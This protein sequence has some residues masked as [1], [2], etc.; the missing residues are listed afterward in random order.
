MGRMYQNLAHCNLVNDNYQQSSKVLFTSI[1][2]KQ[3]GQ[4]ITITTHSP[5]MLKITN[6]ES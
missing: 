4:L 6:A 3:F 1:A 2:N 5:T